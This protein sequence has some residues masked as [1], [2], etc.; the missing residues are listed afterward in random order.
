[1]LPVAT[2]VIAYTT[3]LLKLIT[4]CTV[5]NIDKCKCCKKASAA[6]VWLTLLSDWLVYGLGVVGLV[7]YIAFAADAYTV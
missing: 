7:F 1:M 6:K 2:A 3:I 5:L 4:F